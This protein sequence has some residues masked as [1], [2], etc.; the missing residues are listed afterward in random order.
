MRC[1]Q[2]GEVGVDQ[3]VAVQRVGR[4]GLL[5]LPCGEA[6]AAAAAERLRLAGTVTI[7]APFPES[8]SSKSCSWPAAQLTITRLDSDRR[9]RRNLVGGQRTI[10]DLHERLGAALGGVTEPLGL[11]AGEENGFHARILSYC[12]RPMPS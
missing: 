4:A 12:A 6:N 8:S 11:P 7:S 9:E 10:G 1:E 3:L 2:R 5:P